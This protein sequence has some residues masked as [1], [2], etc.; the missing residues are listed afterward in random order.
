L[1]EIFLFFS[2]FFLIKNQPQNL[3]NTA[4]KSLQKFSHAFCLKIK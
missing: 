3:K 2:S 1:A 4:L